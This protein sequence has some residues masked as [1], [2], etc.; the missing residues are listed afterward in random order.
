[1][2]MEKGTV[3]GCNAIYREHTPHVLVATD[4]PIAMAIQQSGYSI[5]HRFH[6]RR[7]IP[8]RG[9]LGIPEKYFGFSSGPIAVSLAA[10]D[11]HARI[12]MLGFDLGPNEQGKFNNVYAGTEFYKN[13]GAAPTFTGNWIKQLVKIMTDFPQ[14][15]FVRVCGSTTNSIAEFKARANHSEVTIGDFL[16]QINTPKDL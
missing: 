1:M 13:I 16:D 6:T 7:P 8:D 4:H 11:H 12:Y 2:L 10:L 9:G 3:Y 15:Q 14:Q 5:Q